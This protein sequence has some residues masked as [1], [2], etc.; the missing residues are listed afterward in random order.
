MVFR[1]MPPETIIIGIDLGLTH[2]GVAFSTIDMDTPLDVDRWPGNDEIA[3]KV[4]TKLWYRAGCK[5]PVS[6]GFDQPA[7]LHRGMDVIDC[8][9]L[10]LDPDFQLG[11]TKNCPEMFWTDEDVQIWFI[12]FL[13]ALRQHI[14]DHIRSTKQ[15]AQLVV[16]DWRLH[17]VEYI[18]SFPTTWQNSMVVDA[19]RRI[20][21]SSGFG[22][23]DAH[24][25]EIK[26][27]EAAAAAVYSAKTF[28][29]QREVQSPKGRRQLA[30]GNEERIRD[31]NVILICDAGG[32]TTDVA[33]LKVL[34]TQKFEIRG[35]VEEV[36][37]LGQ[38][39]FVN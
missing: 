35:Q 3:K 18:F 22:N 24:S 23:C 32:G 16:G 28:K 15:L 14:I 17:P 21:M 6:W 29:N 4:P 31:G 9:K 25:V 10:Y 19:F 34:E 2:T 12:D 13:T 30:L 39:D 33:V 37:Q 20:V 7:E 27:S 36:L 38:L 8:F 11:S 1:N 5:R 26:M